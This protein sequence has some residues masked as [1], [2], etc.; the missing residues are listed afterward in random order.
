MSIQSQ[1]LHD[2]DYKFIFQ[3]FTRNKNFIW[4]KVNFIK[5]GYLVSIS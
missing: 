2:P 4:E 5:W 3:M 1:G